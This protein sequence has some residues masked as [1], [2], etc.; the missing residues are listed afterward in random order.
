[1]IQ[2]NTTHKINIQGG[3]EQTRQHL[4]Q[5]W[6]NKFMEHDEKFLPLIA[7]Y[8][9]ITGKEHMNQRY[10]DCTEA[11]TLKAWLDKKNKSHYRAYRNSSCKDKLCSLCSWQTAKLNKYEIAKIL[12]YCTY[13]AKKRLLFIRLSRKNCT[14][15]DVA[16]EV[17]LLNKAFNR[18]IGSRQ[19]QKYYH[20]HIKRLEVTYNPDTGYNPHIHLLLVTEKTMPPIDFLSIWKRACKDET[21]SNVDINR[22]VYIAGNKAFK[23]ANYLSKPV[24]KYKPEPP[25]EVFNILHTALH[26]KQI[27]SYGGICKHNKKEG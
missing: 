9:N 1:M 15:D 26:G 27:L 18:F 8:N 13:K 24:L 25:Q 4:E 12:Q 10:Q 21:I 22:H 5:I 6:L 3:D 2:M 11:V 16:A 19:I 7:E 14:A 23:L 20:G 17:N